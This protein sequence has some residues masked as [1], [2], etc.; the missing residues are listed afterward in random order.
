MGKKRYFGIGLLVI[1]LL[2]VMFMLGSNTIGF[3]VL[4]N[5]NKISNLDQDILYFNSSNIFVE[6]SDLGHKL[7]FPGKKQIFSV[8]IKNTGD[9]TINNCEIIGKGDIEKW[10]FSSEKNDINASEKRSFLFS[11]SIPEKIEEKDYFGRMTLKCDEGTVDIQEF[12]V[13]I[14]S[15]SNLLE[16]NDIAVTKEGLNISYALDKSNFIGDYVTVELW[17]VNESGSEIKRAYDNAPINTDLLIERNVFIEIPED[18]RG[19]FYVFAAL[20]DNINDYVRESVLITGNLQTT[21]GMAILGET[22]GKMVGYGIFLLI[23]I[24]GVF[25]IVWSNNSG[26]NTINRGLLKKRKVEDVYD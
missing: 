5:E 26:E 7:G 1:G 3:S 18:S 22:K 15:G 6:T 17:V 12:N 19:V 14:K 25:F 11:L 21:S 10:F 9:E 24:V 23:I 8:D 20:S 13:S 16:I 2:G 4:Q